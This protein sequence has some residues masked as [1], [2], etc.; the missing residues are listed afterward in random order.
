MTLRRRSSSGGSRPL[1]SCWLSL[2]MVQGGEVI[3]ALRTETGARIKVLEV[4]DSRQEERVVLLSS[5]GPSEGEWAPAQLALFRVH[6]C[7]VEADGDA[8]TV[9]F[10]VSATSC[11]N[12]ASCQVAQLCI[13]KE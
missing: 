9:R 10:E 1:L 13:C 7:L 6:A 5:Q 4:Q 11:Q 8:A 12:A 3:K 2:P